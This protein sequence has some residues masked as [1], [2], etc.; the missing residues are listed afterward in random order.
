VLARQT[1]AVRAGDNTTALLAMRE[2][3]YRMRDLLGDGD[4]DGI[5]RLLHENWTLK[6]T[7]A[8]GVTT[9]EIDEAYERAWDAGALGGKL[10]GAGGG[11][12]LLVHA[13][14]AA[15]RSVRAALPHLR[16]VPFRFSASGSQILHMEQPW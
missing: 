15:Q 9:P 6:R 4:V 12:F 16:E 14:E 2:L 11:G 3:S 7:V 8:E 10:L 5:G 1:S 13:P